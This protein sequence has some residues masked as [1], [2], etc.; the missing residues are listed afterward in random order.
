M[1][2]ALAVAICFATILLLLTPQLYS[3]DQI[4]NKILKLFPRADTN[5]DGVLSETEYESVLNRAIKKYPQADRDGDGTLSVAEQTAILKRAA[6]KKRGQKNKTDQDAR[7]VDARMT[8][9]G[10]KI[11][12]FKKT[13]DSEGQP[14]ELKVYIF[15]PDGHQTQ[16]S[17]PAIVF[18]FGGGW[19]GG[20]PS[21]FLFQCKYLA[22]RGMVA[23]AADY[24]VLSRQGTK[25]IACVSDGKSAVRW[26]RA[27]AERLGVDP[28]KV[29]A[30]GGSAGGHVAACTGVIKTLDE[31]SE[32]SNI[33]SKPNALVLFNPGLV[34]APVEGSPKISKEAEKKLAQLQ[35]RVGA[36]PKTISPAHHVSSSA[37]PTIIFHGKEDKTVPYLT[38]E[39]FTKRMTDSG[40]IC[41]LLGYDGQGHGFFNSR[42]KNGKYEETLKEMDRFLVQHGFIAPRQA[43]LED[44]AKK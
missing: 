24:R 30:G 27:N 43:T 32:D 18:F 26:I 7:S 3:D 2:K 25:V 13:T 11:E 14:V 35:E 44:R 19:K 23:M 9:A 39:V 8:Q 4:K 38:A 36:D 34:L 1:K 41:E 6:S 31:P 22:E 42:S 5:G 16:D 12:V 21:Q 40:N 15:N 10:A 37:P 20:S 17:K 29:A 33:S 28:N